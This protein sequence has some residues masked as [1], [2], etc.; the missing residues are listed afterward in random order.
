MMTTPYIG[1]YKFKVALDNET[2]NII[3]TEINPW[4]TLTILLYQKSPD[5]ETSGEINPLEIFVAD[6]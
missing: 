1:L 3:E 5:Y 6:V 2:A 4:T